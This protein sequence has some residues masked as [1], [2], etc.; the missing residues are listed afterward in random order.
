MNHRPRPLIAAS[1]A[2]AAQD[3]AAMNAHAAPA[4]RR[5]LPRGPGPLRWPL[6]ALATWLGAWGAFLASATAGLAP[7][8]LLLGLL[9]SALAATRVRGLGRRLWVAAGFPLSALALGAAPGLPGWLWLLPLVPLLAAY[10]LRAWRDAPFFPTPAAAL[11]GLADAT[12]P[13]PRVLEAGCGLGHGLA[14]LRRQYPGAQLVGLEW[15][16]LF[17]G[18]ARL[19]RRDAV[20]RRGDLWAE[21][22]GGYGLVYLFQ[23]PESM[24]RAWAK[25]RAEMAPGSW[26]ASLEFAVPG[27]EPSVQLPGADG[28]PVW[29]YRVP[30][31]RCST[32][33][34]GGR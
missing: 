15:S 22:W 24:A 6:P 31:R 9:L 11:E 7:L 34:A 33:G 23:R 1:A 10:P 14:A 25:A 32:P 3:T 26:L 20:V 5:P 21:P 13:V 27:L 17:A 30:P 2:A 12:G 18:L 8:G 29:L 28:R 4:T 19:R 16:P